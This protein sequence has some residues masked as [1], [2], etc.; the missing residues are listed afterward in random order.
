MA[1]SE[2]GIFFEK[3]GVRAITAMLTMLT[4]VFHQFTLSRWCRYTIHLPMKSPGVLSGI[5][6][7]WPS[8]V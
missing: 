1:T 3:R 6:S 7:A 4:R 8:S 2:P 5:I